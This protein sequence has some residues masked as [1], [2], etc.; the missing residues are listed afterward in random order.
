LIEVR[1]EARE[2]GSAF[3]RFENMTAEN[4]SKPNVMLSIKPFRVSNKRS[5]TQEEVQDSQIFEKYENLKDAFKSAS[6]IYK[7]KSA[8]YKDKINTLPIAQLT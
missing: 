1:Q 5:K 8:K 2:N 6:K 4:P 7:N 3:T